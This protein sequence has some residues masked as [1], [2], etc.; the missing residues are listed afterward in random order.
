MVQDVELSRV[1]DDAP[2]A[3]L[4]RLVVSRAGAQHL[5]DLLRDIDIVSVSCY[6]LHVT[7][8]SCASASARWMSQRPNCMRSELVSTCE[9]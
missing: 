1:Q 4:L 8:L 2:D 7:W 5:P 9:W 3:V 6:M